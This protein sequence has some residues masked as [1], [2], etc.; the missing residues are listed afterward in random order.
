[1]RFIREN[2]ALAAGIGL[3]VLLMLLF[4]LAVAIPAY[5]VP[6]PQYDALFKSTKYQANAVGNY[7]FSVSNG[8]LQ[9]MEVPLPQRTPG[10]FEVTTFYRYSAATNSLQEIDMPV[11]NLQPS[12]SLT[13][14]LPQ[15][16]D[17]PGV[18]GMYI[19][20]SSIA[21]DG[22]SFVSPD[23]YRSGGGLFF[24]RSYRNQLILN[25]NSRNVTVK[26]F[27]R[28]YNAYNMKFVGWL[29]PEGQKR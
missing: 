12:D 26:A 14:R 16:V 2:P 25:K 11:L 18:A 13:P 9:A 23:E 4:S 21:P 7:V 20:T 29:I 8:Q 1:M 17:L 28:S 19:D 15:N 22:Y 5:T 27:N 10:S 24:S 3:P 6:A